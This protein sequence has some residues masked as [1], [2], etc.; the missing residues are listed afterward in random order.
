M[1]KPGRR[2][3]PAVVAPGV[4]SPSRQ[5]TPRASGALNPSRYGSAA[6]V[7]GIRRDPAPSRIDSIVLSY[8]PSFAQSTCG[9]KRE[10][11]R[12]NRPAGGIDLNEPEQEERH[13]LEVVGKPLRRPLD[14]QQ[15]DRV[16]VVRVGSSSREPVGVD[17]LPEL[18]D[19][20]PI[21]RSEMGL[22]VGVVDE[23]EPPPLPRCPHSA[24]GSRRPRSSPEPRAGPDPASLSASP[25]SC[26]APR[27]YP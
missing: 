10:H 7:T 9:P 24:H 22:H 6:P 15:L 17:R 16:G 13:T 11:G 12:I 3:S 23:Q 19:R 27:R 18:V 21:Q 14:L 8:A 26:T 4:L 1:N 2:P 20:I 5:Q 25:G